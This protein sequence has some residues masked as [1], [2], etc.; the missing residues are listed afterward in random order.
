MRVCV[1]VCVCLSVCLCV[2]CLSVYLC[3]RACVCVC[4]C[5]GVCIC[6]YVCVS[7][8]VSVSTPHLVERPVHKNEHAAAVLMDHA[9]EVIALWRSNAPILA[10]SHGCCRG[11]KEFV[12][13]GLKF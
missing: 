8:S 13:H 11:R 2:D 9:A 5:V 1:C 10:G 3:G 6:V 4:V 12:D 7:A